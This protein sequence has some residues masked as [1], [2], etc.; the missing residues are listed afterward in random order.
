MNHHPFLG[1]MGLMGLGMVAGA[2]LSMTVSP[3]KKDLK[4]T[5][6]KAM[7][8]MGNLA[9]DLSSNMGF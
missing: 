3:K 9:D 2:A 5:A 7:R 6:R 4:R 1:G 8:N